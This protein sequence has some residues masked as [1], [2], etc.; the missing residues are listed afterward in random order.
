MGTFIGHALP[1]TFFFAFGLWC[2]IK[3]CYR[4]IRKGA[5]SKGKSSEP[6]AASR[7]KR[8][9][10]KIL[11]RDR[12]SEFWEGI[13][14]ICMWI[15]G[16]IAELPPTGSFPYRHWQMF[17]HSVEGKP[18]VW[19]NKWQHATM[20]TFFGIYGLALL[21]ARTCVRGLRAYEKVFLAMAFF[22]EGVLFYFH[23]HGRSEL[24][25]TVHYML[26]I[27]IFINFASTTAEIWMRDDALLPFITTCFMMVQGTWFW[28]AAFILYPPNGV[29]WDEDS[30]ANIM[31]AT[32][33]YCWHIA[34]SIFI[35]AG[36]YGV[37]SLCLR[38]KGI[39]SVPYA[40]VDGND[41]EETH[42]SLVE[43]ASDD[44]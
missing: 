20:Y 26:V 43:N 1:G 11:R 10:G 13:V 29:K 35:I 8:L 22:V 38:S 7:W 31:F 9:L 32:M 41:E 28:Q 27:T 14:I 5:T 12:E 19:G 30:H 36:V 4:L 24:D 16:F 2:A 15:I 34:A 42:F 18:F 40:H 3:Y 25:I 6:A 37:V 39:Y 44:H 23:V 17:D 33:A 21:L